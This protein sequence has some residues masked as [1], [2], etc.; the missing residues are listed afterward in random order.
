M[1]KKK[2]IGKSPLDSITGRKGKPDRSAATNNR[3]PGRPRGEIEKERA[4]YHLPVILINK[5]ADHGYWQRKSASE[6]V[7]EALIEHLKGKKIKPRPDDTSIND[8]IKEI[9]G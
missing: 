4:T 7:T 5:V 1:T 9:G 3:G 8:K 2:A 6:I